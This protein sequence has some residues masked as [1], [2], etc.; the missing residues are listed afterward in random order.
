[1]LISTHALREE[2]D[3]LQSIHCIFDFHFYPRPPRGGRLGEPIY[4]NSGYNFYPRPP[5]GG[6]HLHQHRQ[7]D[8]GCIST[9]ALREEGDP[10]RCRRQRQLQ[11]STHALREEGDLSDDDLKL[12]IVEISTHAL[13][14]EGDASLNW[15]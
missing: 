8:Q 2:G 14:E 3:E 10:S 7:K 13:R 15:V 12:Q 5:R 1:M 6:R 11:I 9:H 4:I